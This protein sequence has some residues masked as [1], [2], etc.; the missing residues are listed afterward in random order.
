MLKKTLLHSFVS[1]IRSNEAGCW[2]WIGRIDVGGYG[3]ISVGK[4]MQQAHRVAY[5]LFGGKLQKGMVLDHLC[6]NRKCVNPRH[7]EQVTQRE[8]VLRGEGAPAVNAKKEFCKN[9][10]ALVFENLYFHGNRRVCK[11]CQKSFVKKYELENK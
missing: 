11:A 9:G 3:Q 4:N 6:R 10:H 1:F 7:L 2:E 8:N 5:R